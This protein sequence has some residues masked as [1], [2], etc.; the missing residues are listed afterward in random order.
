MLISNRR[1]LGTFVSRTLLLFLH[2]PWLSDTN[3]RPPCSSRISQLLHLR[4]SI[5][6]RTPRSS[7]NPKTFT[8][9]LPNAAP[10]CLHF[11]QP[12]QILAARHHSPP[13]IFTAHF[14]VV[15]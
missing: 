13:S 4:I 11:S 15:V 8:A 2:P 9:H 6:S 10:S 7:D 14:A 1:A 12:S 5:A 3:P